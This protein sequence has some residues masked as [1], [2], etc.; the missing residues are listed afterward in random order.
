MNRHYFL[1]CI[2]VLGL[3]ATCALSQNCSQRDEAPSYVLSNKIGSVQFQDLRGVA[4]DEKFF[5]L[6]DE[7]G[8]LSIWHGLPVT[9]TEEPF[10]QIKTSGLPFNHLHSDGVYLCAAIQLGQ[11]PQV[12]IY[13]VADIAAGGNIQP[14][15]TIT[16]TMQLPLNLPAS[17]IT[18]N[19]SFAIANTSGNSVLLW[20]DVADAGDPNKVI[21]LGQPSLSSTAPGIGVNRLFMP[22][23]LAA[24]GNDLWVGEIKFSSRILR[25]S[26][27]NITS[28][29]SA[30]L[31]VTGYQ[32]KQNYPNPFNPSTTIRF[33]L[34]QRGHVRLKVFDVNGREVATLVDGELAAGNHAVRFEANGLARGLYFYKITAGK[35]SQTRKAVLM[36]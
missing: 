18:F 20:K 26:F 32:L 29:V 35:F 11:P 10:A 31:S 5:Y 30:Q 23:A 27:G 1:I 22:A 9:G 28:V 24:H 12:L 14:F 25:F 8:T 4:L 15:K 34:P 19:N 2:C 33:S 36:K 16:R 21:V 3:A 17:A 13:R 7:D 6:A